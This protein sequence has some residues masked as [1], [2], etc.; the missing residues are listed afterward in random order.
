MDDKMILA[1]IVF[2]ITFLGFAFGVLMAIR[3]MNKP[4]KA[5]QK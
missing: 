3:E 5:K 1:T 2:S 4:K